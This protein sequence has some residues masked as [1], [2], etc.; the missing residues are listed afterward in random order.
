MLA[1]SGLAIAHVRKG[2]LDAA[3]TQYQKAVEINPEFVWGHYY[4]AI[5]HAMKGE[6]MLS[7]RSLWAAVRLDKRMARR[8]K[9]DIGFNRVR[10]DPNFQALIKSQEINK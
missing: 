9:T 8:A 10:A 2:E 1:Y 6:T 3:V 7:I 5:V 4:L